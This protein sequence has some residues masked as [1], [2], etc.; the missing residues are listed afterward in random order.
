MSNTTTIRIEGFDDFCCPVGWTV[1]DAKAEIR[2][3][4]G[5][6]NGGIKRTT[7]STRD[8]DLIDG[9]GEYRFVNFKR[10]GGCYRVT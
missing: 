5:L 10:K 9:E 3:E 1:K 7:V 2:S 8:C 4:H 6:A